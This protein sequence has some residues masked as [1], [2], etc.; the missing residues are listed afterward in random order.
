VAQRV[1]AGV[2]RLAIGRDDTGRSC[3]G[4][5]ARLMML[6][7]LSTF[8]APLGKTRSSGSLGQAIRCLEAIR[9]LSNMQLVL[10]RLR[11]A[12]SPLNPEPLG[13]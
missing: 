8:P 6:A 3:A 13:E 12:T 1:K 10:A 9:T 2:F 5:K 11:G 4:M 7:W